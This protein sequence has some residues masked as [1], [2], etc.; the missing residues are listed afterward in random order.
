MSEAFKFLACYL[1]GMGMLA[2]WLAWI[3]RHTRGLW[4]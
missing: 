4:R 1:L 2:F 3:G